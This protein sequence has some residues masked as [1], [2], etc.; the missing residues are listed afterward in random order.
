MGV[1]PEG[2]VLRR[3]IAQRKKG[4]KTEA[5]LRAAEEQMTEQAVVQMAKAVRNYHSA[6]DLLPSAS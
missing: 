4:E 3:T 5:D 2:Q 1:D 6:P